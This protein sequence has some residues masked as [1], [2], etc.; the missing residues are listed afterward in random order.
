MTLTGIMVRKR[1]RLRR[2]M[3]ELE[4]FVTDSLWCYLRL[5]GLTEGESSSQKKDV[6]GGDYLGNS[7]SEEVDENMRNGTRGSHREEFRNGRKKERVLSRVFK[8]VI[9]E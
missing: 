7:H 2:M 6:D 9:G 8:R 4:L 3:C 1:H 5:H